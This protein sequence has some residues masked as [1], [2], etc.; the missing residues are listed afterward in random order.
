[1]HARSNILLAESDSDGEL[2]RASHRALGLALVLR[3]YIVDQ[4][5][6]PPLQLARTERST[7]EGRRLGDVRIRSTNRV[8]N[9]RRCGLFYGRSSQQIWVMDSMVSSFCMRYNP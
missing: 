7:M 8:E 1:L 6:T 3:W 5:I 4:R 2:G 9:R